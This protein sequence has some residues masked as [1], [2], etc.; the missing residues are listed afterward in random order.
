MINPAVR[1]ENIKKLREL[2]R[3]IPV[4]MLTT[5]D[6]A[7]GQLYS[8]PVPAQRHNF[9]GTLW[10][11]TRLNG[12]QPDPAGTCRDA[13][14]TYANEDKNLYISVSGRASVVRDLEM[15]EEQWH[16]GL[17]SWF[18]KGLDDPDL[19]LVRL[20]VGHAD[21]WDGPDNAVQRMVGFV[22]AFAAGERYNGNENEHLSLR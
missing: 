18:P 21:Y 12:A 13:I 15:M 10:F 17:N 22:R 7:S 16:P 9:D 5:T 20:E 2:I 1:N 6:A 19:A 4:A 14:V 11:F 3:G 8:R